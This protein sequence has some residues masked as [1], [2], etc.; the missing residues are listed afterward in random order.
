MW[1]NF[2]NKRNQVVQMVRDAK[3]SYMNKLQNK[4]ADPNLPSKSWYKIAN[5]ITKMKNKSN[6]PPPLIRNGKP[7]VHPIDKAQVLNDHFANISTINNDKEIMENLTIPNFSLNSIIVTEQDVKDQLSNLN[8]NKPGGPDEIMPRLVKTFNTNLIKPLTLLF[9]R[10][11]QL[12]QVPNQWKLANVCAI[13][14]NQGSENDPSNYRPISITSCIGKILEKIIF[15][16]LYNYLQENNILT[17]FQSGF[18]PKDSTV[19][20]LLEIYHTIIENLDKNKDIKFIFCDVSKAFDKV[21]H[22]GL[23]HKLQ[24]YGITGNLLKWMNSYLSGRQQRV[25]NEGFYSTWSTT[26]AG[27]PQGSVLGPY[28]FLLYIN[29]ITE[30]IRTNIRLFADDT[31]LYAVIENEDSVHLLNEDLREIARWANTW[32]IILNPTKTK[33]MTFTRKKETNWPEAKF[34]N[35]TIHDEKTH[36]H[37]G[38]TFSSDATWDE[39]IQSIYKKTAYR[40][41]IMRMLKYDLDRKSLNRFYISF[42]RPMLEYGNILWDNCTKQQSDLLESIQLDAAR[43]ITGLR[44]GTSHQVLLNEAGLAPLAA[45]RQNAKLIQFYKILNNESPTYIDEIIRKINTHNTE[46]NLRNTNLKHPTP[47][48]SSYQNSF[49]IA[50]TDLWNNL[51]PELKNCTSLYSFKKILKKRTVKSPNYYSEGERRSNILLCQLRNNKSQLNFDLFNDHLIDSSKCIHCQ[52]PETRLHFL[53]E[54]QHY[55]SQ[56]NDLMNWLISNPE[57]Y[58][59]INITENDLLCGNQTISDQKNAELLAAVARYIKSTKRFD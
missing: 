33:S 29:D 37:L 26:N 19:N 31:S 3:K 25:K 48:T 8:S 30:N 52:A 50:T 44:K 38:I 18:R 32:L 39:H 43:I 15:K 45:R 58:G 23:L 46:Y 40:L 47:R 28:L 24:K 10:S 17:K 55:K 16:Y 56:R 7:N 22:K 1:L 36:T 4:L 2:K 42:I 53:L 14:K 6:P 57:I 49:F 59:P 35:I 12:G 20:Q 27:V 34:N 5:D 21:W 9:N 41:N 54:C 51:D 11:L 13:F